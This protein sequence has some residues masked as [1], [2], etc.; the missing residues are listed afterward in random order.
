[1]FEKGLE[2]EINLDKIKF[3]EVSYH[4]EKYPIKNDKVI[5]I[6]NTL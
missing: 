4:G 3:I 2:E 6:N 1:M 5:V